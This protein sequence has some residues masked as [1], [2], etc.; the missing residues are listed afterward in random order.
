[1]HNKKE[2]KK[3]LKGVSLL[4]YLYKY[5][6]RNVLDISYKL[7]ARPHL[8]NGA[9]VYDNQRDDL[10]ELFEQVQ[11]KAALNVSMCWQGTSRIKV[12]DELGW[13]SLAERGWAHRM[14]TFYKIINGLA[15][16]YHVPEHR[17]TNI[18]FG[19]RNKSTF[20]N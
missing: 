5:V 13:E 1:M 15:P 12:Y 9:G 10:M 11:Y 3:A 8:D 4:K 18:N 6:G 17:E 7:Y 19:D 20:H 2:E 16:T 14:T